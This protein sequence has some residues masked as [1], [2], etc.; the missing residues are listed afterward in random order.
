MPKDMKKFGPFEAVTHDV[1]RPDGYRILVS[2]AYNAMGL[3]GPEMN[4]IAILDENRKQVVADCIGRQPSGWYA[5]HDAGPGRKLLALFEELRVAPPSVFATRVP[6]LAGDRLRPCG[7]EDRTV[8]LVAD[9]TNIVGEVGQD[10]A[11]DAIGD[12]LH[13]FADSADVPEGP[14]RD[15]WRLGKLE[16]LGISRGCSDADLARAL[17]DLCVAPE[18]LK[19][20]QAEER[21]GL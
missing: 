3:I 9:F 14:S 11:I 15:D 18:T 21:P 10:A 17:V 20:P 4:G 6:V 7:V 16:A 1:T 5:E 13:E 19:G 8:D 2:G 12:A